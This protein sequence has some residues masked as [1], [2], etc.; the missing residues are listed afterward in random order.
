MKREIK[1]NWSILLYITLISTLLINITIIIKVNI[2][3]NE[4]PSIF[5]YK[6]IVFYSNSMK[7]KLHKGDLIFAKETKSTN[8]KINDIIVYR[9]KNNTITTHRV[10]N[11]KKANNKLCFITKGDN[12]NVI[13][14]ELVNEDKIEGRY[15]FK[16]PYIGNILLF[17]Q[18]PNGVML[19]ILLLTIITIL[20]LKD[21]KEPNVKLIDQK[22]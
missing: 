13:D 7:P 21:K 5:G 14:K 9:T 3:P 8:I 12:N 2:N 10:T 1:F 15:V 18:H 6:P 20:V 19:M 11:I 17:I 16:I 4:L 22:K